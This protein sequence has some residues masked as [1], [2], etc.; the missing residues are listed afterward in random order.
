MT[1]Q[2]YISQG[3]EQMQIVCQ[4]LLLTPLTNTSRE[5]NWLMRVIATKIVVY[6]RIAGHYA[7][8]EFEKAL[9]AAELGLEICNTIQ[10]NSLINLDESFMNKLGRNTLTQ[11]RDDVNELFGP[12]GILVDQDQFDINDQYYPQ[13][14]DI[15]SQSTYPNDSLLNEPISHEKAVELFRILTLPQEV[16]DVINKES[17]EVFMVQNGYLSSYSGDQSIENRKLYEE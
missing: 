14:Q 11:V 9:A 8:P 12:R 17:H 1:A 4:P 2:D 5:I 7:V 15:Q 10:K 6:S 13:S 16:N 3:D